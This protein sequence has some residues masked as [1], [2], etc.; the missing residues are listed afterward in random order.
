MKV[1]K[2]A[3]R[4]ILHFRMYS[5]INVL[6]LALSL[7]CVITIFRYA[8]G[9]FT[10]DHFNKKLNRIYVVTNE[11]SSNSGGITFS[12]ISNPNNEKTF[13]NLAEHPGVEKHS[14]FVLPDNEEI[15]LDN[16]KYNAKVLAAD[17]I[18]L[19]IIDYP[20]IMGV[21]KLSEPNSALITQDF[22]RKIFGNQ[23]PVGKTFQYRNG[24]ILTIT[25]VIGQTT[26]KS[27]LS[28]DVVVSFHLL[29]Q[30][31]ERVPQSFVLL[32][33]GA[34]YREINKQYE[35][36]FE[37]PL[38]NYQMRYQLYP[39]SK[40]YLDKSIENYVYN[41]G[42]SNYIYVLMIVGILILLVGIINYINIYTVVILRR[43][44]ELS[45]KKVFGAE[46]H[47]IFMQLLTE[48]LLMIGLAIISALIIAHISSS[49]IT[50]VLQLSQIP[51]MRF[52]A[53]LSLVLLFSLS[54][55]ATLYPFF[56]IQYSTS[57]NL[58][59]NLDKIRS[60]GSLRQV[61]LS[62]QYLITIVMIVASLF[63]MKQLHFML[64]TDLGYRSKDIIKV[65]FLKHQ[66]SGGII[67]DMEEWEKKRNR[68]NQIADE[69]VQKMNASPLFSYWTYG[70]SPNG[71]GGGFSFK[72]P[73]GELKRVTLGGVNESWFRMFDIPLKEG[74]LWTDETENDKDYFIIVTESLLEYYGITDFNDVLLQPERRIWYNSWMQEEMKTNPP[75]RI[76]GVVKD[77]NY[78]HLSQKSEPIAFYYSK[79][80]RNDPIVA[81]IVP[82]QTK[83]AIE[84]LRKLHEETVGGEFSYS[85][86]EDEIRGMYNEDKRIATVYAVFTFIAIFISALGLFGLSLFDMQRRRKEIAI[87]KIN[88]AETKDLIRLLLKKYFVML[89][90]AFAV[91]IP[92]ALFAIHKYLENF[93]YKTAVSWW[94]F[95]IALIVTASISLLTLIWQTYKVANQNP[96]EV[97][98]AD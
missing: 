18:F 23:D 13:V 12:G 82:G 36:F 37:M 79:G 1:I 50:N 25:G 3:I 57:I 55:I 63:F 81:A 70:K 41:K 66:S 84:F 75:Y 45:V 30:Y 94:L 33:P 98:K 26:T 6:G 49:L 28:F 8:N 15:D 54:V 68:E 2:L 9:E 76:V 38:W 87:R 91:S 32:Y 92:V 88:G 67:K 16:Q 11:Y 48:N 7:A 42:N 17:S 5:G 80:W 19:K 47:N 90:I 10:V 71:S 89:S 39:L 86:V 22:A 96:A 61:F 64:N 59:H 34:N 21:D 29:G 85:F 74:R 83:A 31:W 95:A 73:D 65:Q 40:V 72:L 27:T 53:L 44:R 24:E 46:G 62:F 20:V 69:I 35:S 52:D 14:Q 56:R 58:L 43:G 78:R 97:V 60:T 77:F 51:N 4:S 93:A